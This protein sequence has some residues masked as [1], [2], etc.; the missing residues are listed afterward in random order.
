MHIKKDDMM[1]GV[2]GRVV[3]FQTAISDMENSA[4]VDDV[5]LLLRHWFDCP[6]E[7]FHAVPIDT[8]RTG[9]QPGW[10]EQ[11][12][13]SL[14]MDIHLSPGHMLQQRARGTCMIQVDMRE[15]NMC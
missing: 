11:M 6:P 8:L 3:H 1:D 15:K 10:I 13:G 2:T 9:Y 4:V 14:A 12:S 7:R 5:Q